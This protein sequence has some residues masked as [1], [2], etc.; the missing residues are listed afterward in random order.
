MFL[1][2]KATD[3]VTPNNE[4]SVLLVGASSQ[5]ERRLN[6]RDLK[7]WRPSETPGIAMMK[8]P[9]KRFDARG[10][11]KQSVREPSKEQ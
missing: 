3:Q 5:D 11:S 4:T 7:S 10:R 2:S 9:S 1:N 8:T 6:L